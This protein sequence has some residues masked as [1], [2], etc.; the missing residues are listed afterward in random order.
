MDANRR[1]RM[2]ASPCLSASQQPSAI[3]P[4]TEEKI[5]WIVGVERRKRYS[6]ILSSVNYCHCDKIKRGG[7]REERQISHFSTAF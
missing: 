7:V 1:G 5:R 2:S 4:N 3:T 6:V